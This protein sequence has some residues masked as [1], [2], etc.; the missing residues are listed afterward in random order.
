MTIT[1]K[2]AYKAWQMF[3][4]NS[5]LADSALC[6]SRSYTPGVYSALL[7]HKRYEAYCEKADAYQAIVEAYLKEQLA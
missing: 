2:E 4:K 3:I 1:A 7:H 6:R 5:D